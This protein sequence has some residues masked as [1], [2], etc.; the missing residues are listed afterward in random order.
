MKYKHET[1][2]NIKKHSSVHTTHTFS[3]VEFRQRRQ[4][5][6][7]ARQCILV[8]AMHVEHNRVS[9]LGSAGQKLGAMVTKQHK[10]V[11]LEH[12]QMGAYN[13]HEEKMLRAHSPL[14]M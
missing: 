14:K 3:F 8:A 6:L 11:Q 2:R 5:F 4:R 13:Y 7:V 9:I 10:T 1:R 12:N